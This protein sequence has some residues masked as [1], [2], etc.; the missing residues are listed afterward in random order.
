MIANSMEKAEL[1]SRIASDTAASLDEIVSGIN[2]SNQIIRDISVSSSEQYQSINYI[3]KG[4]EKVSLVVHQNSATAKQSAAA[5]KEMS[6]QSAVLE[7]LIA[8]FQLRS[9]TSATI[10]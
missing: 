10:D 6:N 1:G 9:Q 4:I 8:Q 3:N 7:D 5:S 2:E